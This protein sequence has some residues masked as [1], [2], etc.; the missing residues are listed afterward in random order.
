MAKKVLGLDLGTNSI[1]WTVIEENQQIID[2]GINI[3]PEGTDRSPLG[4][5]KSLNTTRREARM[6]RRQFE[7]RSRRKVLLAKVLRVLGLM[8]YESSAS[9]EKW[10]Q[11]N[12]YE[13]RQKAVYE[14][15]SLEELGR[16]LYHLNQRRGFKSSRKGGSNE[17][18]NA[19]FKGSSK[20]ST[21]A[22]DDLRTGMA[23]TQ[24]QTVGE[25][26]TTLDTQQERIRNRYTLRVMLEEEFDLIWEKQMT[27]Y[28]QILS[29]KN[30]KFKTLILEYAMKRYQTKFLQKGLKEFIKEY[31]IF[32]QRPL[33]SQKDK[34]GKCSFEKNKSRILRSAIPFQEF[35]LW[36]FLTSIRVS[37]NGRRD[38]AL[39]PEEKSKAFKKANFTQK[40][41]IK[42]L[43]KWLDLEHESLNYEDKH[44]QKGNTTVAQL[45]HKNVFGQKTWKKFSKE[46]QQQI[47][48]IL[49]DAKDDE[50]LAKYAQ[51][52]WNLN[53]EVVE[54][55][56]KIKLEES[57]GELSRKAISK[58]LPYMNGEK[59]FLDYADACE[60][61]GYNH[62]QVSDYVKDKDRNFLKNPKNVRNP[63]VQQALYQV[64]RLLNEIVVQYGKPDI[65]RIELA[66][67]LK[68]PKAKRES[69]NLDNKKRQNEHDNIRAELIK[70]LPAKFA[71]TTQK[72]S[73]DDL[74]RYKL[75]KECN[76]TCPYTNKSIGLAELYSGLYFDIEHIVPYSRSLDDS[77]ANKTLCDAEFNRSKKANLSPFEMKEKGKISQTEFDKILQRVR[78]FKIN[79]KFSY[80]KYKKFLQEKLDDEFINRQL[81]DTAY[82]AKEAKAWLESIFVKVQVANGRS[83]AEL[84]HLWGLNNIL[85]R[86]NL[87]IKNR[88][89][90]RH[91][92]IDAVVVACTTP[93]MLQ[94]LSRNQERYR[95]SSEKQFPE[96]WTGFRDDVK[97][98]LRYIL[99]HHRVKTKASG[100]LHDDSFYA[101]VKDFEGNA[102]MNEGKKVYG[103]R[104]EVKMLRSTEIA[105]IADK[106]IREIVKNRIREFGQNP[107]TKGFKIPLGCF[108]EPLYMPVRK[109]GKDKS[110]ANPIKRVKIHQNASDRIE[111]RKGTF[112]DS[113]NNH[114]MII[115]EKENGKRGYQ[116][117]SMLEAVQRQAKGEE[118]IQTDLPKGQ[119]FVM[120]LMKNEMILLESEMLQ[121]GDIDWKNPDYEL[122]SWHL[123]RVQIISQGEITLRHHIMAILGKEGR[124]IKTAN[125]MK[126]I[127]VEINVL[128]EIK[129]VL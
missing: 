79:N 19:V 60:K 127:K 48:H 26:F 123:Y 46:K 82:I 69:I 90:H 33:K 47:W 39:N 77:F 12:P 102:Q 121:I 93:A 1:G 23:D 50:W 5:E 30:P 29:D 80:G 35:R 27:F 97:E 61:V 63:I 43:K 126:G 111:I 6:I 41:T 28:P 66:R 89:D 116:M 88:E 91:H 2:T 81:N 59:G 67:E 52:K 22:V 57:Y 3:F 37:G 84:R 31:I 107:D 34:I 10:L 122:I 112:V 129:P 44:T 92:A 115:F 20:T 128:G 76:K 38:E 95:T 118:V 55:L 106:T 105:K 13:L 54:K 103:I 87:N 96:P 15:L 65:V 32:Y 100:K 64:K 109:K 24:A 86:H 72:I 85:N 8:P 49:Q 45:S 71:S 125:S 83:T 9:F 17:D 104:K 94:A 110:K 68:I 56:C 16:V 53:K 51:E 21:I 119:K 73:R 101:L 4:K 113:G 62:S 25:Y 108:D 75:W 58:I 114:H 40:F 36:Q 124:V 117:I 42:Q 7:R 11:L 78:K 99:V 14:K 18:K 70:E 74:I 98:T 120:S